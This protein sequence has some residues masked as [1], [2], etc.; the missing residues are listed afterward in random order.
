MEDLGLTLT[1]DLSEMSELLRAAALSVQQSNVSHFRTV[2]GGARTPA[3]AAA[4]RTMCN[5]PE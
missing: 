4:I 1:P 2:A 3:T 5:L